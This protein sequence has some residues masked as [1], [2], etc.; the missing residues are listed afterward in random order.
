MY[1]LSPGIR[2]NL[3]NQY[4]NKKSWNLP[5]TLSNFSHCFHSFLRL[6]SFQ[7]SGRGTKAF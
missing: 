5:I 2:K 7:V 4:Q 1:V 3:I 6:V